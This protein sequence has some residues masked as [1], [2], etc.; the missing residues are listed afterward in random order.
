MIMSTKTKRKLCWNCEGNVSL[1]DETCP[2]CGVS[3]DVA[4]IAGTEPKNERFA[5][6]FKI[7]VQPIIP[8]APYPPKIEEKAPEQPENTPSLETGQTSSDLQQT[9][10]TLLSLLLGTVLI[11]FGFILLLFSDK[12]GIFTLQWHGSYW[13]IYV[14]FGAP[15]LYYGW[16]AVSQFS[17]EENE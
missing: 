6:P 14:L 16:R 5:S 10:L 15:L 8:T 13:F 4:P 11:I 12:N 1:E 2:Y 17:D 3:L 9:L 7:S